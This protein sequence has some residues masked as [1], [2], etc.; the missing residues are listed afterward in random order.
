MEA[1]L[2][3]HTPQNVLKRK[4]KAGGRKVHDGSARFNPISKKSRI[5]GSQPEPGVELC[6]NK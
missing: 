3:S 4:G 1:V 5:P 6:S 2:Q